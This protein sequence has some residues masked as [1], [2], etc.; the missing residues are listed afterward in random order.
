MAGEPPRRLIGLAIDGRAIP[1]AEYAVHLNG[2]PVG[3]VTSGMFSPTLGRGYAMALV[4]SR[5]D[6]AVE[7]LSVLIRGREEPANM[8]PLPFYRREQR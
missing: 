3:T 7:G 4:D 1:R 5:L 2:S 6:P 8:V